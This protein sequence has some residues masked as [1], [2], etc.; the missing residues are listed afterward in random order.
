[1]NITIPLI[2]LKRIL[3][4]AIVAGALVTAGTSFA[5][6]Q[7]NVADDDIEAEVAV[8]IQFPVAELGGCADKQACKNYCDQE[9]NRRTCFAFAKKH[10]LMK[11]QKVQKIEK[12]IKALEEGGGGPGGCKNEN[13][14]ERYCSDVA[15]M[16]ECV[17]FGKRH[18]IMEERELA[19]A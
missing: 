5:L 17:E 1:M 8:K 19:E 18:G 9:E 14:C 16:K 3:F 13:E 10:G 11:P 15:N 12:Q 4:S 2:T 6:A 7:D